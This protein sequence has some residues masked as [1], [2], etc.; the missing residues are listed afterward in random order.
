V[1]WPTIR[2]C[3]SSWWCRTA[4]LARGANNYRHRP[5]C[6]RPR[7][8]RQAGCPSTRLRGGL[9][10]MRSSPSQIVVSP[11]CRARARAF[12]AISLRS[13]RRFAPW[14][15]RKACARFGGATDRPACP[16]G[17]ESR[18]S[19]S[20]RYSGDARALRGMPQPPLG[21]L[22]NRISGGGEDRVASAAQDRSGRRASASL[23]LPQ[24]RRPDEMMT[25]AATAGGAARG[26]RAEMVSGGIRRCRRAREPL[27]WA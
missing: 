18:P 17:R 15:D 21:S 25:A 13:Y 12:V 11:S 9:H 6:R 22:P 1:R 3:R 23:M 7:A 16:S 14:A 26:A 5:D 19:G 8:N 10:A 24:S 2:P 4:L 27:A 20:A